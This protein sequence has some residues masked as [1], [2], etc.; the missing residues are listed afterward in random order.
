MSHKW[1]NLI[2]LESDGRT[3]I[4]NEA[5]RAAAL[6]ELR[7][8]GAIHGMF[9]GR[10][11]EAHEESADASTWGPLAEDIDWTGHQSAAYSLLDVSTGEEVGHFDDAEMAEWA[12]ENELSDR[13]AEFRALAPGGQAQ[14][15]GGAAPLFALRRIA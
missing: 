3:E 5:V 2:V 7:R 14:V 11:Y 10:V 4:L 13:L 6:A 9:L 1:S 15:G 12:A 8:T